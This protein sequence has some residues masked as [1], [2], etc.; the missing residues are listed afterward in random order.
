MKCIGGKCRYYQHHDFRL[1]YFTCSLDGRSFT[2]VNGRDCLIKE[3]IQDM[4]DDLIEIEEYS[5]VIEDNQ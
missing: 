3:I 5:E 1:S 2:K 4:K